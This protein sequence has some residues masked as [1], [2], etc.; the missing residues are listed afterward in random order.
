MSVYDDITIANDASLVRT[1]GPRHVRPEGLPAP[2]WPVLPDDNPRDGSVFSPEPAPGVLNDV[3]TLALRAQLARGQWDTI[4][5][6]YGVIA[7][8]QRV[9]PGYWRR[10]VRRFG[11]RLR[12]VLVGAVFTVAVVVLGG[13]VAGAVAYGL[14]V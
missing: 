7:A 14:G 5:D 9:H 4:R 3:L 1:P 10:R 12:T 8:Y 6:R 11:R 2:S 13:P